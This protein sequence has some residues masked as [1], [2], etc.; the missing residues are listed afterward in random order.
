MERGDGLGGPGEGR[1]QRGGGE[2]AGEKGFEHAFH[3]K[4]DYTKCCI[5]YSRG[6]ENIAAAVLFLQ[7]SRH[8]DGNS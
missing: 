2:E 6:Q 7:D 1:R 4:S 5:S 8:G 3:G